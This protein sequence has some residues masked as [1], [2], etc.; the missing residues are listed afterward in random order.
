MGYGDAKYDW[1]IMPAEC[2]GGNSA[3]PVGDNLWVAGNLNNT[4]CCLIGGVARFGDNNGIFYYACD[5]IGNYSSRAISARL[6]YVPSAKDSI[7]NANVAKWIA[8]MEG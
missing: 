2:S 4:M 6:M 7:Y 8:K 1:V 3:L 5:N